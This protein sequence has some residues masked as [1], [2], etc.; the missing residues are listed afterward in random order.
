MHTHAHTHICMHIHTHIHTSV[1][2]AEFNL[3]DHDLHYISKIEWPLFSILY[4]I[5]FHLVYSYYIIFIS[6][7]WHFTYYLLFNFKRYGMETSHVLYLYDIW[8]WHSAKICC[9]HNKYLKHHVHCWFLYVILQ[10]FTVIMCYNISLTHF[11]FLCLNETWNLNWF[12]LG[13]R[14]MH[15]QIKKALLKCFSIWM[16]INTSQSYQ[17]GTFVINCLI[18]G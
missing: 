17:K 10:V 18:I 3:E 5:F 14:V 11:S 6:F 4:V 1:S 7:I 2:N 9:A 8:W 15:I 16:H 12:F 13:I